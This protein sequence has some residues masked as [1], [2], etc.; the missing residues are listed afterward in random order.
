MRLEAIRMRN[1]RKFDRGGMAIENIPS[2]LSMLAAPNEFGKSTLFDALRAVLFQK[3][4]AKNEI[5]RRLVAVE[6]T[7]PVIEVDF[8]TSG[9]RYRLNK[10][11]IKKQTAELWDLETGQ[12]I[13]AGGEAHDWMTNLIGASKSGE[14]PTGLLW[15]EQ[16]T[17]MSAP[18][19]GEAG[20]SLLASLLEHQV[21]DVTGGERARS[22]LK[23]VQDELGDLITRQGKPKT[24][25]PYKSLVTEIENVEASIKDAKTRRDSSEHLLTELEQLSQS[26]KSLS[27]PDSSTRLEAEL[28]AARNALTEAREA[29]NLLD[30]HRNNLSDKSAALMRCRE[31]LQQFDKQVLQAK[32]LR[33]TLSKSETAKAERLSASDAAKAVLDDARVQEETANNARQKAEKITKL[34]ARAEKQT[35][36]QEQSEKLKKSLAEANILSKESIKLTVQRNQNSLTEAALN[37]IRASKLEVDRHQARL[38]AARPTLTP[39]LTP[40][41]LE[42]VCLDGCALQGIEHLS[43]RQTLSLGDLG[44]VIIEAVDPADAKAGFEESEHILS[45]LF[46]EHRIKTIK[47][48]EERAI[49]RRDLERKIE[50]IQDQLQ[51]LAPD[52]IIALQEAYATECAVLSE[53]LLLQDDIDRLPNRSEAELRWEQARAGYD[54]C[55]DRREKAEANY[56]NSVSDLAEVSSLIERHKDQLEVLYAQIGAPEDWD[57]KRIQFKV[58]VEDAQRAEENLKSEITSKEKASPSLE[59]AEIDLKRLEAATSNNAKT[60]SDKKIREAKVKGELSAISEEGVGEV[61]ENL[62]QHRDSLKRQLSGFESKVAVLQLLE[63]KLKDAQKS[64]QDK[65][66]KPVFTEL[67]PLLEMVFPDAK[68]SLGEDFNAHEI[69]RSGRTEEID[70]LSGGTQEQVAVLTRLAFAQ[71]MAKREREMP[72]ILDDALVWCDDDRL[73][74]VFRALHS[75][76][77]DIQCIVLTC[78]ERGFSTL[79]APHLKITDWPDAD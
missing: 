68:I 21:G 5:I 33:K 13:K 46:L 37:E 59:T 2:G 38:D 48:A 28:A 41:G 43:G 8:V 78:H 12:I 25:G 56:N 10:Q 14:G 16:G 45:K 3:Y 76:A 72:V 70:M 15:V 32:E 73:E 17:S 23:R 79:G 53:D 31:D 61:L 4:T 24:G 27:D 1:V 64:L 34:C 30:A 18:E 69:T 50:R 6:G 75:A 51:Q 71:L 42:T 26:I 49:E 44:E 74:R 60:L 65:F 77:E 29:E 7:A 62:R 36:A 67:R 20:K 19:A 11:F 55:R 57:T 52:G 40:L 58:A 22:L 9:K 63:T 54:D 39:Q 35:A 66:L 47:Q